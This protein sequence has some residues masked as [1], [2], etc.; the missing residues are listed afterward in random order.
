MKIKIIEIEPNNF[1][2]D[3]TGYGEL[4]LGMTSYYEPDY[5]KDI[6]IEDINNQYECIHN[7]NV[8]IK[9][10]YNTDNTHL[11]IRIFFK[12]YQCQDSKQMLSD[13]TDYLN[14]TFINN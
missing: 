14:N 9:V 7:L 5:T 8:Q 12:T 11:D 6:I 1:A 13:I 3:C 10:T 2:I 4:K